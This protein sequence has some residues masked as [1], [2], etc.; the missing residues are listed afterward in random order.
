MSE[1]KMEWVSASLNRRQFLQAGALGAL[2]VTMPKVVW[3]G[4]KKILKVRDYSPV[5]SFDPAVHSGVPEEGACHAIY[6]KLISYVPGDE[7]GWRLEA[8]ESIEQA[9]P[10]HIKFQLKKGIQFTNGYGEMTAEDV[11]FSLERHLDPKVKSQLK[12]DLGTFSHV[13]VTGTYSGVI[14]LKEAFA[15]IWMTGLAYMAGNIICKKAT[16]EKGGTFTT[17]PC[18]SGPYKF[19]SWKPKQGTVLVKNELWTGEPAEFD[20]IH[21]LVIDDEKSAEIGYEAGDLDFTR[22]SMSSL[23][24]Y[25]SAPQPNSTLVTKPSLYY[26]WMGMNVDNSILKDRRIRKAVQYAVDVESVLEASYFG[27]AKRA[28]GILAPGLIG[29][30]AENKI[31]KPDIAK[32]T[33]LLEEAGYSRGLE[34]TID[35]L[36]KTT[37]VTAAQVIQASLA[38]AGIKLV[39][40][41]HD[42]GTFWSLGDASKGD[43]WKNVQLILNRFSSA[44]EPYYATQWFIK[45]QIGAWNWER[46]NDEE[47]NTLHHK[48]AVETDTAKRDKMYKKMMDLMEESGAYTFLTHE[49][50]PL[51][52]RNTIVPALRPD[53]VP[54]WRYFKTAS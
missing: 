29:H 37:F 8:A 44:P 13:D 14:V 48:A 18:C 33:A 1:K 45:E 7:W 5:E 31:A 27:A 36:N 39:I 10:T 47:Y 50:V 28:T 35:V 26:V 34:L 32:A 25:V 23:G 6:N 19:K 16:E 42:S 43:G 4:G 11:K 17:P 3:A 46:F 2:A 52:Y 53:G 21:I 12:N 51:I 15:P 54:M 24:N 40:N 41:V 22:I 38:Q 9:D 30:R 20:E 49:A